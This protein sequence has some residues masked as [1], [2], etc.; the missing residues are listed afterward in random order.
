[1]VSFRM[2]YAALRLINLR[3]F[4]LF[5]P[6]H[7]LIYSNLISD[8]CLAINNQVETNAYYGFLCLSC[9]RFSNTLL[10]TIQAHEENR[11][12]SMFVQTNSASLENV[13]PTTH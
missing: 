2:N 8:K 13:N 11:A 7:Q 5:S 12:R 3:Y 10:G 9:P 1:M 4:L 6:A